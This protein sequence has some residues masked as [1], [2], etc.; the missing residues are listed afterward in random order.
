MGR[1][2]QNPDDV[3][4]KLI[5]AQHLAAQYK[6][7]RDALKARL[8]E[9]A[10]SDE[11]AAESAGIAAPLSLPAPESAP[12]IEPEKQAATPPEEKK[13]DRPESDESKP[14]WHRF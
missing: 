12:K 1:K 2:P 5:S 4:K 10:E 14:W 13:D 3:R 6:R 9:D 11:S 8:G 7:E